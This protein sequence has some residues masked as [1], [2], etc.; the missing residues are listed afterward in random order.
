VVTKP[1]NKSSKV[2]L[3]KGDLVEEIP[4]IAGDYGSF[5]RQM[6]S[7]LEGK[8]ALPIE[9]SLVLQVAE[10]IDQARTFN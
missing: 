2:E 3:H 8:S 4:A 9:K 7:F 10:I 1:G 5:Y 6:Y